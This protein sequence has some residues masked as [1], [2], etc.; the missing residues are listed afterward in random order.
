MFERPSIGLIVEAAKQCA[1]E[2][3]AKSERFWDGGYEQGYLVEAIPEMMS[4][5]YD[6]V[7]NPFYGIISVRSYEC[8]YSK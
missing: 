8:F 6:G 7:K 4:D 2:H 1:E 3:P 5:E